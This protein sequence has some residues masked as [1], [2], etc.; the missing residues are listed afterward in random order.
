MKNRMNKLIL[1]TLAAAV[2]GLSSCGNMLSE[3]GSD[4]ASLK[5]QIALMLIGKPLPTISLEY[6]KASVPAGS[7]IDMGSRLAD[8]YNPDPA[9]K[10]IMIT[11]RNTG[12]A[13]VV[14][15]DLSLT[16]KYSGPFSLV[17]KDED[18]GEEAGLTY[19]ITIPVKGTFSF[20]V[21]FKTDDTGYMV[22]IM[23]INT[24]EDFALFNVTLACESTNEARGILKLY[25]FVDEMASGSSYNMAPSTS[26]IFTIK[27]IGTSS[28]TGID[29]SLSNTAYFALAQPPVENLGFKDNENETSFRICYKPPDLEPHASTVRITYKDGKGDMTFTM[30]LNAAVNE[31]PIPKISIRDGSSAISTPYPDGDT[32]TFHWQYPDVFSGEEDFYIHNE[33]GAG[34]TLYITTVKFEGDAEYPNNNFTLCGPFAATVAPDS[35]TYF[36]LRYNPKTLDDHTAAIVISYL[37]GATEKSYVL[38]FRGTSVVPLIEVTQ[39]SSPVENDGTAVN[40]DSC[41]VKNT[42]GSPTTS[43]RTITLTNTGNSPLNIGGIALDGDT[44]GNF[45]LDTTGMAP[46]LAQ[47]ESTILRVIFDPVSS[48]TTSK[49]AHVDIISNDADGRTPYVVNLAG[50]AY[51]PLMNITVEVASM[52]TGSIVS[53]EGSNLELDWNITASTKGKTTEDGPL[54]IA[55][56]PTLSVEYI[57]GKNTE[58]T[59][60]DMISKIF[61]EIPKVAGN[62]VLLTIL[63]CEY[64]PSTDYLANEVQ[65]LVKYDDVTNKL[66]S[67]P[68][69]SS[70]PTNNEEKTVIGFEDPTETSWD[71]DLDAQEHECYYY[72]YSSTAGEVFIKFKITAENYAY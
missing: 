51:E 62:G 41:Y 16:G 71:I 24:G 56:Y 28:L 34:G 52:S 18:T 9:P 65:V 10:E 47:N 21:S 72:T 6:E 20:Y 25:R 17:L 36:T 45:T 12:I 31:L 70:D 64:D 13:D 5:Q 32:H 55:E 26:C 22:A 30:T 29:V 14:I 58:F 33:G 19:P 53:D 66:I 57:I 54:T 49:E 46:T 60:D 35:S 1:I 2:F 44:E 63:T 43:E 61:T 50:T 67:S 39:D 59:T 42:D 37:D 48:T 11:L 3:M 4:I 69:A 68:V 27:N 8:T 15:Q 23:S 40:F 7:L 38:N